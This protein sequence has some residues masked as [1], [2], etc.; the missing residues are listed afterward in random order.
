MSS[1]APIAAR[2]LTD[3]RIDTPPVRDAR[4]RAELRMEH[5]GDM[6]ELA[7]LADDAALAIRLD[8]LAERLLAASRQ[9][10][11]HL[12]AEVDQL[13]QVIGPAAGVRVGAR[14]PRP[15]RDV[16]ARSSSRSPSNRI[17]SRN[18]THFRIRIATAASSAC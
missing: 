6:L 14:R 18:V 7:V 3:G 17:S 8:R 15:Q 12:L 4:R 1:V 5:R 10:V 11:A 9:L 2:F 16:A 13:G